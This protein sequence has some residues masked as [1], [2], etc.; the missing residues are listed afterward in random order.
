MSVGPIDQYCAKVDHAIVLVMSKTIENATEVNHLSFIIY[1]SRDTDGQASIRCAT[2]QNII[3]AFGT[4]QISQRAPE[5]KTTSG[6]LAAIL[7]NGV[8]R[9]AT[10]SVKLPLGAP[11]PRHNFSI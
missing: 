10:M 6:L 5:K 1:L 11:S 9:R 2:P 8:C 7:K 3:L 4:A